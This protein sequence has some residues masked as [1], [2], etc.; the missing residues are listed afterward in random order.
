M[1][2]VVATLLAM[3]AIGLGMPLAH[4]DPLR[5]KDVPAVF[6]EVTHVCQEPDGTITSCAVGP[7]PVM[8]PPCKQ[9]PASALRPDF[10]S[11]P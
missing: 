10:W 1:K 8:G 5:C 9:F 2:T 11:Q 7:L 3:L 4:A 6:G